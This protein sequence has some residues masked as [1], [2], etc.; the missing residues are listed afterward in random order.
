MWKNFRIFDRIGLRIIVFEGRRK[1]FFVPYLARSRDFDSRLHRKLELHKVEVFEI[2][3][4]WNV[5]LL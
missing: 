5:R 3:N 4:M 1:C 2:H